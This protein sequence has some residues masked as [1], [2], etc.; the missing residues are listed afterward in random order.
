MLNDVNYIL[1][2]LDFAE[3]YDNLNNRGNRVVRRRIRF[4]P[5]TLPEREFKARY[6]F[7]KEGV[8]RLT[9]IL[10]PLLTDEDERPGVYILFI[11]FLLLFFIFF[12]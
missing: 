4:E 12:F 1:D 5:Y 7:S 9:N 6:R 2:I 10:R 8:Q 11:K 3:F